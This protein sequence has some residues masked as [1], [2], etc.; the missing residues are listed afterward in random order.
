MISLAVQIESFV[1]EHFPGFVRCVLTD[2]D[3]V[4]H[5]FLEKAPVVSTSNL[6][7]ESVFPQPGYIGCVIEDEWLDE[8]GRRLV[9]VNT[10]KPWSIESVGGA[11]TFTVL[12]ERIFPD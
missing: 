12:K 6:S 11:K 3:G 8:F 1:D 2:A 7:S 4:R 10:E 9:R 5:E